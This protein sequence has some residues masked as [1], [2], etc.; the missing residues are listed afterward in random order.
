MKPLSALLLSTLLLIG[1]TPTKWQM[2]APCAT[3][4]MTRSEIMENLVALVVQEEFNPTI[5]NVEI[6][7]LQTK[8]AE[9]TSF[10]TGWSTTYHWNF[11]FSGDTIVGTAKSVVVS[12]NQYGV[13]MGSSE[14]YY[15]DETDRDE[16]WY[17]NVRNGIENMCGERIIF[18]ER[19]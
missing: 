3:E 14:E 5:I 7:L 1:C 10:W 8:T 2:R 4:E 17:W 16:S 11:S 13:A 6:G 18:I 15:N 19:K 12:R 9:T